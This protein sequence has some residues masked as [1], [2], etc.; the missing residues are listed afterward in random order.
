VGALPDLGLVPGQ[1]Q[2][3]LNQFRLVSYYGSPLGR[4]LGI[5]G[6]QSREQ[7]LRLIRKDVVEYQALAPERLAIPGYHMVTTVANPYPPDYRHHVELGIIEEWVVSAKANGV[8]VTLDIQPGRANL[9]DEF[10]RIRYLLYE[11]HVHL[12]IDPEFVMDDTQ[13]PSVHLGRLDAARINEIQVN[14]NGI[15]YE[16]GLNR[17]LILHQFADRMLPD[18]ELIQSYP[19]VE[20]VIDGD[21]FGSPY[22]KISNYNQYAGEPAF[23]YGGFKLFPS[24]GDDPLMS[25]AYVM[26]VLSPSPVIII[27]Q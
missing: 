5:L 6:N 16:I 2:G 27:Y 4:A 23:E 24:D 22:V 8:A 17:V 20:L 14:M 3:Y 1:P 18:K 11:P 19:F 13:V 26:S 15:G 25:P 9:M 10:N 21:G 7:T 12:A